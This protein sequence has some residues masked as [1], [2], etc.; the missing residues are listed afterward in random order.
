MKKV[1]SKKSITQQTK[2]VNTSFTFT[3]SA[4]AE[5]AMNTISAV[6][7]KGTMEQVGNKRFNK[8]NYSKAKQTL[9]DSDSIS[10]IYSG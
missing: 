9:K 7:H 1:A 6:I 3:I 5:K 2:K 10:L 4:D 8:I